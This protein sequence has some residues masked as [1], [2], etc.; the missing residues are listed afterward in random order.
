MSDLPEKKKLVTED[1]FYQLKTIN[2]VVAGEK[3]V[4]IE[5]SRADTTRNAYVTELFLHPVNAREVQNKN[6]RSLTKGYYKDH[7]VKIR[8]QSNLISFLSNRPIWKDK[9]LPDQVWFMDVNGGEPYYE[10]FHP[11][12]VSDYQWG[13]HGKNIALI[14]PIRPEEVKITEYKQ[15]FTGQIHNKESFEKFLQEQ[16]KREKYVSDPLILTETV[17]RR[18][19][20]YLKGRVRQLFLFDFE[21]KE[22]KLLTN[23]PRDVVSPVFSPD[24][25]TIYYLTQSP[26]GTNDTLEWFVHAIDLKT[27]EI[28]KITVTYGYEPHLSISP[29]GHLL[30]VMHL[31]PEFGSASNFQLK[32]ID[33]TNG[34]EFFSTD[35]WDAHFLQHEFISDTEILFLSPRYRTVHIYKYDITSSVVNELITNQEFYITS[36][37]F[38]LNSRTVVFAAC[39]ANKYQE[40]FILVLQEKSNAPRQFT[41]LN[42]EIINSLKLGTYHEWNFK[43]TDNLPIQAWYL[44]PPDFDPSRKYP[45]VVEVHGGPHVMWSPHEPTMFHE[46]QLLASNGYIVWFSNPSGSDG[47]GEDYRKRLIGNWGKAGDDVLKGLE[48]FLEQPFI[49]KGH[50]YLTGGSYGGWLTAWLVAQSNLFRAAVAQRGVYNLISMVGTTDIPN[51]NIMEMGGISPWENLELFW[52]QSPIAHV[53]KVQCPILLIHSENDFRVPISQAE[54]YFVA[55]KKHSKIAKLIRYPEDGHELSRSGTPSRRKDRLLQILNWFKEYS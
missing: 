29:S 36:F 27:K 9:K 45:V 34:E 5:S 33:L 23:H 25:N 14:I 28:R 26:E 55:L 6:V 38:I 17:Y 30:A 12:G 13:P 10:F 20:N 11:N 37:D 40:A 52:Q 24:G 18:G 42:Q 53:E 32:F 50:V 1:L 44:T 19:T 7:N 51:F 31:N 48:N 41:N 47:Y 8:P 43:G 21:S 3:F 49:D 15:G 16:E 22:L 39:Q 46:F 2:K 4:I 54:E 35:D